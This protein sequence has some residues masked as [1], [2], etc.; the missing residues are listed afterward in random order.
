MDI[1]VDQLLCDVV[2]LYKNH[3]HPMMDCLISLVK[4]VMITL[5]RVCSRRGG[6]VRKSC[7]VCSRKKKQCGLERPTCMNCVLRRKKGM[8]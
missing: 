8:T 6:K 7:S 3:P 1:N 2:I 4:R 5:E